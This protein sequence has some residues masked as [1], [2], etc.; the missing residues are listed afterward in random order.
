M[1]VLNSFGAAAELMA[2]GAVDTAPLL[3]PPFGLAE[4]P[5]A[6]TS[7]RAGEGIKVQVRPG[8]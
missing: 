7:V 2:A 5:A 3:G 4:F 1:A 8:G 6:L